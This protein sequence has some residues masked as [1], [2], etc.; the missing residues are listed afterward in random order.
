MGIYYVNAPCGAGKSY[1][2]CHDVKANLSAHNYLIAVNSYD[3]QLAWRDDLIK[4]GVADASIELVSC[5]EQDLVLPAIV[6]AIKDAPSHGRVV[7]TTHKSFNDLPYLPRLPWKMIVDEVP[8]VQWFNELSASVTINSDTFRALVSKDAEWNPDLVALTKA[9][10][11]NFR[12]RLNGVMADK[13]GDGGWVRL[14]NDLQ[15]PRRTVLVSAKQWE[16]TGADKTIGFLTVFNFGSITKNHHLTYLAANF[17]NSFP[18]MIAKGQGV[19]LRR[20]TFA[21]QLRAPA[22]HRPLTIEYCMERLP[23]RQFL[24]FKGGKAKDVI[25]DGVT[26]DWEGHDYLYVLNKDDPKSFGRRSVGIHRDPRPQ[27]QDGL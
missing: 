12:R 21:S 15:D 24:D 18:H 6:K 9:R 19:K 16:D 25:L 1:A 20:A 13:V 22:Q 8:E 17:E 2:A 26:K 11:A 27:L 4:A 14:F 10:G 23:S 7:I 3:H 5:Y